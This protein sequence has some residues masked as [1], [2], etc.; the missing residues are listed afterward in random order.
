M[1]RAATRQRKAVFTVLAWG[2]ALI[3]FFPILY[4]LITSLKTEGEAAAGFSLIPSFTL[5]SYF[6]VQSQRDYFKPFFNSVIISLGSTL[7]A[8]LIGIPAAW[9]MA[10]MR[11]ATSRIG[12]G[13]CAV[14][15]VSINPG[16]TALARIC[17]C[18]WFSA[19]I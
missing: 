5:E 3:L 1:A 15:E 10:F 6:D 7:I 19:C 9:A 16:A 17:L 18:D 12:K 13:I 14:I 11:L 8:L 2:I 4:T